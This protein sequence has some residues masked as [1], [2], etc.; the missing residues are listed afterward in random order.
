MPLNRRLSKPTEGGPSFAFKDRIY[1]GLWNLCWLLL[2]SWTPPYLR[3]WRRV[4]LT[5]FGADIAA[6]A[7]VYGSAKI[8]SP[9]NLRMEEFS[10]IA[11]NVTVYSMAKITL[12]KHSLVS[13]GAHLCSG[14][15]DISDP[16]FR[17]YFKPIEIGE[18]AWVAAEAFIGPGVSVGEGAVLGARGCTFRNLQAWKV[19]AGNPA[20]VIKD[21]HLTSKN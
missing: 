14:T 18:Y 12:R 8:W 9:R 1:R 11:P 10:C 15:H 6:T 16:D 3:N 17:L 21:R 20:R 19:Y 5:I 2:A 4:L 7:N 13:Q